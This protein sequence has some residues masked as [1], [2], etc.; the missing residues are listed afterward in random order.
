MV[1]NYH[2]DEIF[3]HD[4]TAFSKHD[5]EI[6]FDRIHLGMKLQTGNTITNIYKGCAGIALNNL[7]ALFQR[8]KQNNLR[9]L[10]QL[11]IALFGEVIVIFA[12]FL[13]YIERFV[14]GFEHILNFLGDFEL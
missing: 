5:R 8:R 6:F 4:I 1:G 3:F 11:D 10:F 9:I 14:P 2:A 12:V 13:F 7:L